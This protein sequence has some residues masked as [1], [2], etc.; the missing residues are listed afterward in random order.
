[1]PSRIHV[2]GALIVLAVSACGG[3]T[4]ADTTTSIATTTT[5]SSPA[6]T[7]STTDAPTTTAATTTTT[8][9]AAEPT[10][11]EATGVVID[12]DG[13]LAGVDAFVLRLDDGTDLTLVPDEG[14][15]FDGTAPIS[16]VQDHMVSGVPV[17]VTYLAYPDGSNICIEI[18]DASGGHSHDG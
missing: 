3:S 10:E 11:V 2:F 13:G 12:V 16:H 4:S 14:L 6:T 1:M 9:P 18:G 8:V 7:S 5:A 17:A 15:L